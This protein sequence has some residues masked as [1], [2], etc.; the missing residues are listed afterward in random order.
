MLLSAVLSTVP[1]SDA[2]FEVTLPLTNVFVSIGEQH[3]SVTFFLALAEVALV[4]TTIAIR[5]LALPLKQVERKGALVCAFGLCKVVHTLSLEDTV[6]EISFVEASIGPFVA[7]APIF[8]S[9]EVL[10]FKL[11]LALLPSF[12][13]VAVLVIIH[14]FTVIS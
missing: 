7:T 3:Y 5:Q 12:T 1:D 13:S 8:L 2:V 10:A 6:D 9:F 14:P 4:L 11:D